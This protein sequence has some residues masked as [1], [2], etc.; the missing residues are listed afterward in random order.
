MT[1]GPKGRAEV[2]A[3]LIA[4]TITL[5]RDRS[6]SSVTLRGIADLA[7]K[8]HGQVRH[9]FGSKAELVVAAVEEL[10]NRMKIVL[11]SASVADFSEE[12]LRSLSADPS[13][14]RM[15]G[16]LLS[17][18]IEPAEVG[19]RFRFGR[20]LIARLFAEGA[21][22]QAATV[23]ASQIMIVCAGWPMIR[24]LL[25]DS[26]DLD[27]DAERAILDAFAAQVRATADGSVAA[28]PRRA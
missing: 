22:L 8:N 2:E 28:A 15:L 7:G 16:W 17:L 4:A 27:P 20:E 1:E 3:A 10:E 9:Y 5:C 6:P 12:L 21:D 19:L 24:P 26:N 18:D 25:W 13:F 11:A 14:A 23:A